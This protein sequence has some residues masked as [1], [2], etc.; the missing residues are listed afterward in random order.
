MIATAA[1]FILF[2]LLLMACGIIAYLVLGSEETPQVTPGQNQTNQTNNT[3]PSNETSPANASGSN[4]STWN[5]ISKSN[6]E[7]ACLTKAKEEAGTSADLV[8]SCACEADENAS[9]KKYTC[10]IRTADPFTK[11]FANIDC[12]LTTK[13]CSIETNFGKADI[14]FEDL[15][16]LYDSYQG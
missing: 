11:Y 5:L 3:P 12:A 6:V 13:K 2:I 16:E 15:K 4:L 10:D 1:I 8:Y 9:I 14:T 7:K